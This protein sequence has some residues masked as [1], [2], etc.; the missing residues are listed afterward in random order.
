MRMADDDPKLSKTE[1]TNTGRLSPSEF[2]RQLRPELYSDTEDREAYQ[3]DAPTLE[4]HLGSITSRNQTNDFEVFCRRLCERT[5]CP[6]LRTHTGPD[7][8]GDSKVDTET[9]PVS[10]ETSSSFYI[11]T[12]ATAHERWA[13]AFSAQ[14]N[15]TDKVKRDV[16]N[17]IK[18]GRDYKNIV[19]VTSQFARDKKR[20][21]VED[22]LSEKYGI[23]VT[24][25]D[26]SW[27]VKEVM[28][29]DRKDIAFN[30]LKVGEEKIGKFRLG[31][32]D[33]SRAQQLADIE[34]AIEDPEVFAGME[35][36]KV[37]EALVA[38]KLSR[39]MERPRF[40]TDGRFERAVRLAEASGTYRQELEAKYERIWTAFWRFDDFQF[41]KASYSDF[42]ALA[43]CSIYAIDL[44]LLSNILQLLVNSVVSKN[45]SEEECE[46]P[47]RTA[48]LK[49]VLEKI[50]TDKNSPNN[51]LE[52]RTLLL[53]I[54]MNGILLTKNFDR[55]PE[56]WKEASEI[57]E[58]SKGLGEFRVEELVKLID[59]F[60]EV[61]KND[62]EY[63]ELIEKIAKFI[64]ERKSE[65]E[66]ALVLLKR[67]QK[68]IS[69]NNFDNNLDI[70]RFLGKSVI[71]LSKKEYTEPL[72]VAL[73]LLT[74]AYQSA[75]LLWAS[76][77]SC[78]FLGS[79]LVIEGEESSQLPINF[80]PTMEMWASISLE[81]RYIPDFL[82]AFHQLSHAL[83]SLPLSDDTK[84]NVVK[85]IQKF[86]LIFSCLI[87]NLEDAELQKLESLPD[88]LDALG[89]Y[90]SRASL[91]FMLGYAEM[92]QAE[93]FLSDDGGNKSFSHIAN[94]PVAQSLKGTPILNAETSE[95]F[96]TKIIGMVIEVSTTGS[97]NSVLVAETILGSLEA[98]F[99]TA[100]EYKVSPH[101][102]KF[103]LNIMEGN[104]TTPSLDIDEPNMS[105]TVY[106]PTDLCPV[107]LQEQEK[108]QEFWYELCERILAACYFVRDEE[109]FLESL[110]ADEVVQHR[111]MMIATAAN[112]HHR[113]AGGY[114][115]RL[116][117]WQDGQENTYEMRA[118]RP[119]ITTT[120]STKRDN[121]EDID[122][123]QA[124]EMPLPPKD[125][126]DYNVH[127]VIDIHTWDKAKWRGVAYIDNPTYP[128]SMAF[129]FEDEASGRKIFERWM[130]RFGSRDENEE[131]YVSIVRDLPGQSRHHYLVV[132][133]RKLSEKY[134]SQPN[135]FIIEISRPKIM[136]PI[137][138]ANLDR[139]LSSYQRT[140][141][142]YLIPAFG[143]GTEISTFATDLLLVKKEITIKS[144]RD[145]GKNDIEYVHLSR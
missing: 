77:A 118:D 101:T 80:V 34:K 13:F 52:A 90:M 42:E 10:E 63:N 99:A 96:S 19:F 54:R 1:S 106:W 91:L 88:V 97:L 14:K 50:V 17:I 123:Y 78:L 40:E 83:V 43:L 108:I 104:V 73:K 142:F 102:E 75:G 116:S 61:A 137:N 117:E 65:V 87:L 69:D 38:A 82:F 49:S 66:G 127:S 57:L 55:L 51:A 64:A 28:E 5:I 47:Q 74:L 41:L 130:E 44:G 133:A 112:S 37:A 2:M 95:V 35:I 72:A 119:S 3:L 128:P 94:Q 120:S 145:V 86:D 29:N 31:P 85:N 114:V 125:H 67:A 100:I 53:I 59:A 113:I 27:I 8:G 26:R 140:G 25:H 79:I 7:G 24:I 139:F 60:G 92:L 109:N 18:T 135:R 11:G 45:L 48:R 39:N 23:S 144:A 89:L 30:Y 46:L 62:S 81:L 143:D 12:P 129:I 132:I 32:K 115:S 122:V 134:L 4:N 131:I 136:E 111:L 141:V 68:L 71:G 33:Y 21:E 22:A 36:Q 105:G 110:F 124:N 84:E 98:F 138:S 121:K 93:K 107:G 9:Y 16:K 126:R 6:N 76:R 15:W 58:K 103:H 20:S 70:I 56:L